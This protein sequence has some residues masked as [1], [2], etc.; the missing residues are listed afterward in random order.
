MQHIMKHVM[1]PT[2]ED[3]GSYENALKL[4]ETCRNGSEIKGGLLKKG[5]KDMANY[6]HTVEVHQLSYIPDT[7]LSIFL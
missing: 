1:T 5:S 4:P 7:P 3:Q 2:A 6:T